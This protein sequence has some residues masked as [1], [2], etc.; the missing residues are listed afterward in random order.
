M[1]MTIPKPWKIL[2]IVVGGL[3]EL[4]LVLI[5]VILIHSPGKLPPLKSAQGEVIPNSIAEKTWLSVNGIEQGLFIRSENPDHPVILFLHGGPGSPELPLILPSEEEERLEKYFTICYWDQRGAGMSYNKLIDPSTLTVA[6]LVEDTHEVTQ[7]LRKRFH[8]NQIYL[9][10][11][12]WGS[13][14]G[15]KTIEKYPADYAAYIG[16][17]QVTH[18]QESERLAYRYMLD[19]AL[20]IGDQGAVEDLGKYDPCNPHFPTH[21]YLL[22]TRSL[23]MNKY[24][25]GITHKDAS[26]A[27]VFKDLLMFEGYTFTE[28]VHYAQGAM[29]SLEHLFDCIIKDNL[30]DSSIHFGVPL[31]I[32]HG[33]Y[34]YQ[35]SYRLAKQYFDTITAPE[36]EFYT[37]EHS[38]HSPNMEETEKFVQ[39]VRQIAAKEAMKNPTPLPEASTPPSRN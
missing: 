28:K 15:L 13:Y 9:M 30:F 17:G 34:D 22:S 29:F 32:L 36:K 23:L 3:I 18:Q 4:C 12:S 5:L 27:G 26:M 19:H 1:K 35:V 2:L 11:H 25:I 7:Y 37:F 39:I 21:D 31:F 33:Q 20:E 10:G 14:L 24:G 16:I 38:A 8:K 6:Q